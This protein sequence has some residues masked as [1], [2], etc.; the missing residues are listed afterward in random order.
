VLSYYHFGKIQTQ[1]SY[2]LGCSDVS[3]GEKPIPTFREHRIFIFRN[4]RSL[5]GLLDSEGKGRT[6]YL[7]VDSYTK[8]L[9]YNPQDLKLDQHHC[10]TLIT[11]HTHTHTR[12]HSVCSC[13]ICRWM[14]TKI[15]Y[16]ETGHQCDFYLPVASISNTT[17][18]LNGRRTWFHCD[19]CRNLQAGNVHNLR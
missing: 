1:N 4:R 16:L 9:Q 10:Q 17:D 2:L 6:S 14:W 11:T 18:V 15:L 7:K 3:L 19:E 12:A 5:F 8:T 13:D